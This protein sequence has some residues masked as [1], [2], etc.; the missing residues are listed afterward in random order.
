M[1]DP[2]LVAKHGDIECHLLPALANRHGLITGATGTGKTITL[3][4]LAEN[5]SKMGVPVFM[6]DV[7]GDLA[8]LAKPGAENP[9]FVERAQKLGVPDYAMAAMPVVF[10]D[11]LGEQGHP[12][13]T[14]IDAMGPVLLSRLLELTEPQEGVLNIAFRWTADQRAD[15]SWAPGTGA[16]IS[17]FTL[18]TDGIGGESTTFSNLATGAASRTITETGF[19]YVPDTFDDV[20]PAQS[21]HDSFWWTRSVSCESNLSGN[22]GNVGPSL[23]TTFAPT[24]NTVHNNRFALGNDPS[25]GNE[26]P[27]P[28]NPGIAPSRQG[29]VTVTNLAAGDTITCTFDNRLYND[30]HPN[31]NPDDDIIID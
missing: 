20:L 16:G 23:W 22:V 24:F 18:I 4:T 19:P 5:F 12:V 2:I 14:T 27:L 11:I 21:D 17:N 6:A 10:W 15:G 1:P 25:L 31:N 28:T 8:G 9:K 13:R 3:Q 29:Y 7:K 26:D 30:D